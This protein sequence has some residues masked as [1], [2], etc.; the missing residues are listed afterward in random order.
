M[1]N[2]SI[3]ANAHNKVVAG[4][5]ANAATGTAEEMKADILKS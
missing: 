4:E 1:S 3:P 2:N 5:N